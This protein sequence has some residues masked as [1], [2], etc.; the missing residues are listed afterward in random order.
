MR[1]PKDPGERVTLFPDGKFR[2]V[3]ELNMLKNYSILF[4]LWKVFGITIGILV[5]FA[6][7]MLLFSGN[8]D[9][10]SIKGLGIGILITA[11]IMFVLS[12]VGYFFYAATSGWKY[13]VLFI[14]DD[15]QVIHQQMPKQVK[16]AHAIGALTI[17]A[18]LISGRPGTI[19]TAL[20]AQSRTSM[21]SNY[22]SVKKLIP[23][24]GMNLIKV[25]ET[26]EKNRVYVCDE[27]FDFV[28]QYLCTH[29]PNVKR[30]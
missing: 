17:L 2:W 4:D 11:G 25:N 18:G 5:V 24:R 27:D 12:I 22:D 21:T 23:Q 30:K 9:L 28:Y 1:T 19:G 7:F 3:F 10:D 16:K 14:M 13:V 26:L 20:L 29:C 15:Q 8:L 6:F